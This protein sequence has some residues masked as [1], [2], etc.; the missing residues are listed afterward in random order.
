[1]GNEINIDK[2]IYDPD[3][4]FTSE[5]AKQIVQEFGLEALDTI[6]MQRLKDGISIKG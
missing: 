3:K 1:M 4:P 2:D 5:I 6:L